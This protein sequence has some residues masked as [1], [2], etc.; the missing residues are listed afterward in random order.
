M[1][2][3]TKELSLTAEQQQKLSAELEETK[4]RYEAIYDPIRPQMEHVRQE[5]RARIRGLLTAEQ[6]AKF[7]EYLR[8]LDERRKRET[9]K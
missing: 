1:E 4:R 5:G 2:D 3:L 8:R 7:E 6:L 9:G